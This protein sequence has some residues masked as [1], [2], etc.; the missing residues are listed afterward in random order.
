MTGA[1]VTVASRLTTTMR[2]DPV[3][4]PRRFT[5]PRLPDIASLQAPVSRTQPS[6]EVGQ[7]PSMSGICSPNL[8]GT[9]ANEPEHPCGGRRRRQEGEVIACQHLDPGH[10]AGNG[11][12]TTQQATPLNR[13]LTLPVG[14]VDLGTAA[15]PR[16][17]AGWV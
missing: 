5:P 13:T 17:R 14:D 2:N 4:G 7:L 12:S 3:W 1:A 8:Q 6:R 10:F 9:S 15:G 11:L 16:H